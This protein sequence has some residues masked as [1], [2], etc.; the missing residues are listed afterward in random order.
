MVTNTLQAPTDSPAIYPK[1]AAQ[2]WTMPIRHRGRWFKDPYGRTLLMRGV[3]LCG[4]SKLPTHPYPGSTHLYDEKLFWDHRSV[5]F[6][7]RPFPLAEAK[8]HFARLRA[9][10][11]TLIRLLVPWESLEH[12]GPGQ[13]DDNYIDYLRELI[14]MMP[15]YGLK[16]LIDPHQDTWSRYSGGSGAP[17]WTFEIAGLNIRAFKET[18]AA[19]VHNTNAVPGDP[20]PMVWPT[21]YTKL[22]SCTMFT[23]FFAGDT[24]A[25]S[26]MHKGKSIQRFLNDCFIG[27]FRYLAERIKDL[28]AVMG[29]EVMNEPHPGYIGMK[30]LHEFDP[31]VNL[32]FGDAPTP[33][34]SF[35]LGDGIPQTVGVY[36]KSW[37]FPT[38]RSHYRVINASRTS[39]WLDGQSCIWRQHGVWDL[40][41]DGK[42]ELLDSAYFYKHPVTGK[43]VDFYGDFYVPFVNQ[44]AQAVQSVKDDWFCFVEPLANERAPLYTE[45]D[46]HHNVVYAPHWYDLNCVFYKK[47]D[48]RMTHDVQSL[49]NGGNVLSATYFG[50]NGAKK[51]YRGQIRNI[52][53]SGLQNMGEK[54]CILGEVGIP[55]DLN[56]RIAFQTGDYKKHIHFMDAVIH[57]L[58]TNLVSFA[59]WNYDVCNDNEYG[60]HWNGENFSIFSPGTLRLT[61]DD[62]SVEY[63]SSDGS[64]T[65][66]GLHPARLHDGGRVLDAALRPYASKI[67]G[68][69]ESSEFNMDMLEYTLVF[70]PFSE[71]EIKQLV[72]EGYET[73]AEHALQTEIFIPHYHFKDAQ[74]DVQ[75]SH[76]KWD[77]VTDKHTVY[78]RYS[79]GTT[80]RITIKIRAAA[81]SMDGNDDRCHIM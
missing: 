50:R 81:S 62:S 47:F 8:E 63:T 39:A 75:V 80:D 32:I 6:V 46:H 24:F 70:T 79:R 12:A 58:E 43:K 56:E 4:S 67:A 26:C 14:T 13:Y 45:K 55:M 34:Q 74:L 53:A 27:A 23:L 65:S 77:Y 69:P 64:D 3:N 28:D 44:Y 36:I 11:L 72:Q 22:A 17:G 18:G 7:G 25:P 33:L 5:S 16:C 41:K 2:E 40:D 54:P 59:L 21:N 51:N 31:I 20:L 49:Q 71:S 66:M 52:K 15:E 35:A 29:F 19:Y 60:D 1:T 78:H 42:P 10:G 73:N 48:G 57:A 38:K 68:T 76:G 30:D 61:T 9:W 37:P